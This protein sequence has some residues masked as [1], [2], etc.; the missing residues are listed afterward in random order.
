MGVSPITILDKFKQIYKPEEMNEVR[1][2]LQYY[3]DYFSDKPSE[4][5][6]IIEEQRRVSV[7][8]V[9]PMSS[10]SEYLDRI[11][12]VLGIEDDIEAGDE[13]IEPLEE[14]FDLEKEFDLDPIPDGSILVEEEIPEAVVGGGQL[15]AV[16]EGAVEEGAGELV[17]V[18][19]GIAEEGGE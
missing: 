12:R 9:N 10:S 11:D 17:A 3:T 2:Y 16:G 6:E 5:V 4:L 15:V 19:G 13:I 7:I 8:D 1:K 14:K 18:G